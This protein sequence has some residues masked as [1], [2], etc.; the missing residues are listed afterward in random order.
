MA[1]LNEEVKVLKSIDIS[2][3]PA[4]METITKNLLLSMIRDGKV[5]SNQ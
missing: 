5:D 2:M 4:C 3:W 1:P